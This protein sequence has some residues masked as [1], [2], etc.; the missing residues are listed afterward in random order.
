MQ[1][2]L[3][4]E[5]EALEEKIRSYNPAAD[6]ERIAA[7]FD[8]AVRWHDGQMRRDGSEYVTHPIA[9]AM[10][11][12]EMGLDDDSIVAALLHDS[13]EDTEATREDVAS[14]FGEDVA[15]IVDGVTKLTRTQYTSKEQHQME[16]LR[17]MLMA[18]ARDIRVILIKIADRLHNMRTMEYQTAEGQTNKSNETMDV[19]APIA[20]RL[21]MQ[22]VKWELEDLSLRFLDTIA[23]ERIRNGLEA[24]DQENASFFASTEQRIREHLKQGN[25]ECEV[26]GRIKHIY[27]IYRK[28]ETQNKTFSEVL[29]LYAFRVVV[30]NS[31]EC[32]H[33]LGHIHEIFRPIPGKFK[34]YITTPKPNGYQSLHT[35]VI[36]REG[37]PFEVQIRSAEMHHEAE[38]GVAAH[39]KYKQ[40]VNKR[41]SDE[42]KFAWIRRLLESQQDADAEEFYIQLRTDM[43]ADEVFVFTPRSD[44]VNLPAGSTPIDFAYSIHSEIGN[45][46]NGAI[47]NG[48]IVP[49]SHVLQNGDI[50]EV[51]TSSSS[52]G[53]SRDWLNIIKSSEAR[54]KIRIWFK[55]EKRDE[56][57]VHGKVAFESEL[58]RNNLKFADVLRDDMLPRVLEKLAFPTLDDLYATIGYGGL[59]A[60]K[61]VNKIRDDVTTAAK[62]RKKDEAELGITVGES[63]KSRS[64]KPVGGVYVEGLDNCLVK[65]AKC[66]APVPGDPIIGFI[67]RN[68][69]VSVHRGDCVNYTKSLT[70]PEESGRWVN[71]E[72]ANSDSD[73]YHAALSIVAPQRN[74]IV[75]DITTAMSTLKLKLIEFSSKS[76]NGVTSVNMTIEVK[77]SEELELAISKL[78]GISGIGEVRR[79]E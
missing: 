3:R 33:A 29:D 22:R 72:W 7:A 70:N 48:R 32:Y 40:G 35:T 18:M 42:E 17:K 28:M 69:G 31:D 5:Y 11:V 77:N 60:I 68:Q 36:G 73:V 58:R 39:W 4:K 67:T 62:G 23:Y 26:Y 9:T 66:C 15:L 79:G 75:L 19:Y 57:I 59:S 16:N 24:R 41:T 37:I 38:Y 74:G 61:A 44:V 46:M 71:V 76:H 63:A 43:F 47:V 2:Y 30:A 13:I 6:F 50:V 49:Y 65:F 78:R 21:G 10:I 20:H 52:K 55:K 14:L 64:R 54:N 8:C 27:S 53:P 34:D 1:E 25:C 12:A 51:L 45:K 56:N